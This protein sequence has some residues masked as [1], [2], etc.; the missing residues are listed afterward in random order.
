MPTSPPTPHTEPPADPYHEPRREN[1]PWCG[2]RRLRTRVRAARGRRSAP[3]AY[4]V[5]RCRDCGHAFQNPRL[6]AEGLAFHHM[7]FYAARLEDFADRV[8]SARA[9]RRRH[10]AVAHA[11]L[12]LAEPES[13]LDVGT[14][15]AQFPK[16]AR[17]VFPY[18]CF[19]GL[20]ATA[21]VKQAAQAGRVEEA[22]IGDLTNPWVLSC[23]HARYDVVSMLRHLEHAPDPRAELRAALDTLR[24]GGLLLLELPDPR[25]VFAAL[26]GRWWLPH[27]QPRQLHLLPLRNLCQEL[28]AQGCTI[29][30]KDRRAAHLPYDLSAALT[31]F[32]ARAPRPLRW[33]LGPLVTA[34]SALDHALAPVLRRSPFSNAYRIIAR[35]T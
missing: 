24:P 4:G 14:G 3:G 33:A 25:S 8:L 23:L 26:L 27:S 34:A 16:T 5:D 19:D 32:L 2:G 30:T 9:V 10:R 6:T 7:H 28:E 18:T 22:H 17:E 21:R 35:R 15:H 29:L 20:D 31:L 1:C 12:P 11:V 13:W